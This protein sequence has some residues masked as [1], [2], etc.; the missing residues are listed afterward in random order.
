VLAHLIVGIPWANAFLLAAALSP[1][2]PVFAATL[3]GRAEVPYRLRHLLNV[4]SGLNDGLA[5]PVVVVLLSVVAG[6]TI[7][8]VRLA[9]ELSGGVALGFGVSWVAVHLERLKPFA[10]TTLYEPLNAFAIGVL[11]LGISSLTGANE[12]LAAFAAGITVATTSPAIREAFHAFGELIAELLKLAALL[13]F[14]A[15]ISLSFLAEISVRGYVFAA[16]ALL[17]ARPI[18]L[19][20][21]MVGARLTRREWVAAAWF[22]PKGFASVVYGLLILESGIGRGQEL[23]HLIAVV[24]V[25]SIVAHAST[26]VPVA[27][28]FLEDHPDLEG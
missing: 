17:V 20:V 28:W 24:I 12:F 13:L 6:G 22:G 1:T 11:V 5:L 16:L 21:A 15:L 4:E 23:F 8:P 2:D 18:A 27:H 10:A 3:V 9:V 19:M 26:D 25:L 14:G 7:H